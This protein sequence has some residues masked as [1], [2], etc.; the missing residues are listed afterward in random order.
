MIS[1]YALKS[2]IES[3]KD[4]SV[5]LSKKQ[6]E[7]SPSIDSHKPVSRQ[8]EDEYYDYYGWPDY[9]SGP[10]VWGDKPFIDRDR[11]KS[12]QF[13]K[14]GSASASHLG[15]THAVTGYHMQAADGEIGHVEDFI[16]DDENWTILYL[17]VATQ[18]WWPGKKVLISPLWIDRV[19]WEES[20]L[21]TNLSRQ[22]IKDSP[23]YTAESLITR[24]YEIGMHL[25]YG[26]K[27]YWIDEVTV[28]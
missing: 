9:W 7:K 12:G 23:E 24:D 11:N 26:R 4:I 22:T 13:T 17:V 28:A 5:N 18:N 21:F 3:E 19:S 6:I 20:K 25:H 1:P 10:S 14:G 27:G 15:S 16:I 8:F 2:V